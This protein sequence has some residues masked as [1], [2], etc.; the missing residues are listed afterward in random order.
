MANT[1]QN[2][3][4]DQLENVE[5]SLGRAEMFVEENR[6][7]LF[8]VLTI[9][10]VLILGVWAYFRFIKGPKEENAATQ[11]HQAELYL[12]RDSVNW[13]LNGDGNYPGFLQIIDNYSG[14][15]AGNNAKYYAGACYMKLGKFD[16]AIKMLEDFSTSDPMLEPVSIGLTGDAYMEK[17]DVDKAISLYGKA[18][19]KAGDNKFVAP[20]Y[21]QKLAVAYEKQQKFTDAIG[22][23]E[24]IKS[25]FP[26]S[27]EAREAQKMIEA[28][29]QK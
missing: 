28:L 7:K 29:K 25:N 11:M 19:A 16:E 8:L 22:V 10:V 21:M 14:T 1:E 3:E 2:Q 24:K 9:I 23:Y 15:K 17:G 5:Q 18:V 20:L 27:N 13:A 12:Q 26:T 4:Q 6:E